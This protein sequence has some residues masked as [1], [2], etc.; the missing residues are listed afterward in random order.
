[1]LKNKIIV[2]L[3]YLS[4]LIL[5]YNKET[6]KLDIYFVTFMSYIATSH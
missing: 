5:T 6:N 2:Y 4:T 3:H 1:M